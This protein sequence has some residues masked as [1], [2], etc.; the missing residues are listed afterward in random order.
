MVYTRKTRLFNLP[1]ADIITLTNHLD[2]APDTRGWKKVVQFLNLNIGEVR[3]CEAAG[4][5][6]PVVE[7]LCQ[8]GWTVGKVLDM[9]NKIGNQEAV[10]SLL[11]II[12][13]NKAST[14]VKIT[15]EGNHELTAGQTL[16]LK[17]NAPSSYTD[18]QWYFEKTCLPAEKSKD[19]LIEE[20][21]I[22]DKG[23]Y[24]VRLESNSGDVKWAFVDVNIL[25]EIE[26]PAEELSF[27]LHPKD[28]LL[29]ESSS[30]AH[31]FVDVRPHDAQLQWYCE[32][33]L[34]H[35]KTKPYLYVTGLDQ[36][37]HRRQYKCTATHEGRTISSD[38][39]L[40]RWS[41][42]KPKDFTGTS[43]VETAT[44]K[45]A[46]I[47]GNQ[48]Y[49]ESTFGDIVH[50]EDDARDI[51]AALKSMNFKVVSLINLTRDEMLAACD[52]F[53]KLL[54]SGVY[55]VF[56]FAGHG[57][58]IAGE[59]Y[60]VPVDAPSNVRIV[61][62]IKAQYVLHRMQFRETKLN[63]LLLD[64][65][66]EFNNVGGIPGDIQPVKSR[67]NT[68]I[69]YACGPGSRAYGSENDKNGI[70]V[71]YLKDHVTRNITVTN[72][73][74][75]VNKA[76]GENEPTGYQR[77]HYQSS[78]VKNISLNDPIDTTNHTAEFHHRSILWS[79]AN[80][81]DKE[82][83]SVTLLKTEL[84]LE[85]SAAFS[86]VLQFS[87]SPHVDSVRLDPESQ[88]NG[89]LLQKLSQNT[90]NIRNVQ[91]LVGSVIE[92]SIISGCER[93]TVRIERPLFAKITAN[94]VNFGNV[95]DVNLAG[96]HRPGISQ[97]PQHQLAD[98]SCKNPQ[99]K[100]CETVDEKANRK[101]KEIEEFDKKTEEE[102]SDCIRGQTTDTP[103]ES[104]K[105]SDTNSLLP[106]LVK[107]FDDR[108]VYPFVGIYLSLK[109]NGENT[110]QLVRLVE[111]ESRESYRTEQMSR[112]EMSTT[113]LNRESSQPWIEVVLKERDYSKSTRNMLEGKHWHGSKVLFSC[114]VISLLNMLQ[115]LTINHEIS[116]M[117]VTDH[118]KFRQVVPD[119][120]LVI[121]VSPYSLPVA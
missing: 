77:P 118:D 28:Y 60:L 49:W 5:A 117:W 87:V 56:Y 90:F 85:F 51:S 110:E 75:C 59:N 58:E 71:K 38:T 67:G 63:L 113:V 72:L 102:K 32:G 55:G 44:D 76:I 91:K 20:V 26:A 88:A 96:S 106:P 17:V 25:Q 40:V 19:L 99:N 24:K 103:V 82:E 119:E 48:S 73:L 54:S 66:R 36:T 8:R 65:C 27:L 33:V 4:G 64:M 41:P 15:I 95:L 45:V 105:E 29:K 43:F 47:I 68:A 98:R 23:R 116:E 42:E 31:F 74:D 78:I 101:L 62:C 2:I 109:S 94:R 86:N 104:E 7:L 21:S 120:Q 81:V 37:A 121:D 115:M 111:N 6:G 14:P 89:L 1:G 97:A 70:Y 92:L 53:Y 12:S 114:H 35:D 79:M 108:I 112:V 107:N 93:G 39:A 84:Q 50:A 46:L 69:G 18:I 13:D 57:F 10:S 9:L 30:E 83:M 100:S 61:H 80:T 11:D 22:E 16:R 52:N 34:M 3:R